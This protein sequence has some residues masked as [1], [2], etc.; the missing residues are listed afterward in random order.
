MAGSKRKLNKTQAAKARLLVRRGK[1]QGEIA[2][3]LGV[4]QATIS[5]AVNRQGAYA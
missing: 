1:S 3:I 5:L 4:S 2:R